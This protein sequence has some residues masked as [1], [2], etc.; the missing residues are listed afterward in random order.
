MEDRGRPAGAGLLERVATLVVARPRSV[1]A[2]WAL[3]ATVGAVLASGLLGQLANRGFLVGGSESDRAAQVLSREIPGQRGTPLLAIV[4]GRGRDANLVDGTAVRAVRRALRPVRGVLSVEGGGAAQQSRGADASGPQLMLVVFHVAAEPA[5][6]ER[7]VEYYRAA[8]ARAS[9]PTLTMRLFGSPVVTDGFARVARDDLQRSERIAFP[10]TLVVLLVA[11]VSVVAAVLPLLSAAIVLVV[12]FACLFLLGRDAGLSVFVTNT[13]SI[14]ALA[15]SIDFTLFLITRMREE[16]LE[17][18]SFERAIVRTMTTTGRAVALSALTIAIALLALL[19]V[20]I[21]LFSSMAIGAT[22]A[23]VVAALA[24]L[25]LLPALLRLLGPRVNWLKLDPVARAVRRATLWRRLA[26]FV[27]RRPAACIVAGVALLLIAAAP[28][29]SLQLSLRT[30]SSLPRDHPVRR[31]ART[32]SD[33]F[34]PGAPAPV[35]IVTTNHA[36]PPALWR[37]RGIA[38]TTGETNGRH[39]WFALKV[40]LGSLPDAAASRDTVARLRTLFREH[41]GT[42]YVGGPPAAAL[43]LLDRVEARTPWVIA[44]TIAIGVLVL[45]AGLRSIVIPLK[46]VLGTLLTV[47]ATIGIELRLF[48]GDS[49]LE[50]FVP[51]LLFAIVFG[52]SVDYEVFLLS[53][54]R[55][56]VLDGRSNAEA[57]REGLVRSA[58]P[59]TLAGIALATVFAALATSDLVA[60]QQLGV[61]LAVAILIDVT[62]VRCVL[63]PAGVVLLGR[64]NW[65]FFDARSTA[66]G[67][68]ARRSAA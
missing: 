24:A 49:G 16:L 27:T 36:I 1:V 60:F 46:A 59:I 57:V 50:F 13:S 64:W 41:P 48:P 29:P 6:A 58:R 38:Q 37:D 20:G 54:I 19:A 12:T 45:C 32:I 26:D 52:L 63:V 67:V 42:T 25:T 68:R 66:V 7:K 40:V 51:L 31:D 65:W 62:L 8:L 39:G 5:D 10:F 18:R 3:A 14:L 43:D 53:R 17:G 22:I 11:F 56:A 61:G 2:V 4:R 47:A 15:L 21:D 55:E 33:T 9:T 23:T 34:F 28:L 44:L 35:Q 30:V